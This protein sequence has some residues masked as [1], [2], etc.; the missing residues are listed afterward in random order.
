MIT[1]DTSGMLCGSTQN[2]MSAADRG[3]RH[4]LP[5]LEAKYGFAKLHKFDQPCAKKLAYCPEHLITQEVIMNISKVAILDNPN[6]DILG[7]RAGGL[8]PEEGLPNGADVSVLP[9]WISGGQR[10]ACLYEL[11]L[12]HHQ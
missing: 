1:A 5:R 3:A 2:L 11:H 8:I 9:V 10:A 12:G 6:A 7:S 4:P